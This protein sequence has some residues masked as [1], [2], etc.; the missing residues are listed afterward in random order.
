[1]K[2]PTTE[3]SA[4]ALFDAAI[5]AIPRAAT[6]REQMIYPADWLASAPKI[7]IVNSWGEAIRLREYHSPKF[8]HDARSHHR[9]LR[10]ER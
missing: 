5:A 10:Q 1:M 6:T 8:L 2:H 7:K 4:S 9:S 3:T